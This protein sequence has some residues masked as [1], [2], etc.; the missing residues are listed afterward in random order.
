MCLAWCVTA[1][2][3]TLQSRPETV[4]VLILNKTRFQTSLLFCC[5]PRLATNT[6]SRL[7]SCYPN[8]PVWVWA[9][10][11]PVYSQLACRSYPKAIYVERSLQGPWSAATGWPR[12]QHLVLGFCLLICDCSLS[13]HKFVYYNT[14]P[15]VSTA[16]LVNMR[17][18]T[19]IY[20]YNRTYY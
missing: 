1:S 6:T 17:T 2:T 4:F 12:A 8:F 3:L 7:H 9:C 15:G 14:P 13:D 19:I 10:S 16:L 20:L 11:F 5:D 18:Y